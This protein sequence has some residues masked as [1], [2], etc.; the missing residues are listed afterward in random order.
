[1]VFKEITNN[2][3]VY[4]ATIVAFGIFLFG[5][6][7][8]NA[9]TLRI[10]SSPATLSPGSIATLSVVLNSE[11][12]AINNAEAK[13]VFPADLLEIV[14]VS[15]GGSIFSLWVE[16]P[17][18]SNISGIIAF[19]GGIPAPGFTG[20]YG[21]AISVVVKAKKVG[22][23]GIIFSDAA[24]RA[25]DGLGTNVL[26]TKTGKTISI[27]AKE[28]PI[29]ETP[30]LE[31]VPV[32]TALQITSPTH[33]SQESWYKDNSPIYRWKMPEGV[34]AI[35]AG[36]DNNTA[37]SPRVTYSPVISEKTVKD[38]DDGI[39]YF[40]AR[41]RKNGEWGPVSTYIARIDNTAPKNNNVVFTYDDT[42]KILN[43]DADIIDETSGLDYYEIH[44]NGSIL[45]KV[46]P[47]EFAGGSYSLAVNT[48]GDN[49]IKLVAVDRAGNSV[50]ALGFFKA[51]AAVEPKEPVT[52]KEQSLVT[53]GSFV[54]PAIY[55]VLSLLL[56]I[57][58]LMLG[59]FEFGRRYNKIRNKRKVRAA[60]GDGDHT[61]ILILLKKR[62]EK[63]LEI[64]QHTRHGRVLSKEEKDIKEAIE[65][66]LDEVD[67]AIE[68][69]W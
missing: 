30:K 13:I 21:T 32:V 12:V 50:E 6:N 11:G 68:E 37:G 31:S 27:I 35:Q 36:I 7:T 16:E 45:K 46:Q 54:V 47:K 40:K 19:N 64:L 26:N 67:Q 29:K 22:Q 66:D 5:Y 24:V 63:H 56:T 43:I 49:T 51:T 38:L 34:T 61:K 4:C 39:W 25:N 58:I 23:A 18:Y 28:E 20:S 14:S 10:D 33:P 52:T 17:T 57:T 69:G 44:L 65:S 41:A 1:M 48:P 55:F 62:L 53:I 9:A 3:I 8:A 15:K 60:L 59:A 2:K 42:K